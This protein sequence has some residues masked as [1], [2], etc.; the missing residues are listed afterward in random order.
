MTIIMGVVMDLMIWYVPT[1]LDCSERFVSTTKPQ[2]VSDTGT[3]CRSGR[4]LNENK[5]IDRQTIM[6]TVVK[7]KWTNVSVMLGK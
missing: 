3:M 4:D 1:V 5:P 6:P 2:N 7:T